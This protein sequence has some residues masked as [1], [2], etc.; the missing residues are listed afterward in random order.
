[1]VTSSK[2][3]IEV[4]DA[5]RLPMTMIKSNNRVPACADWQEVPLL[6]L[7][8]CGFASECQTAQGSSSNIPHPWTHGIERGDSATFL[9]KESRKLIDDDPFH[10][11]WPYW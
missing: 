9:S 10:Y 11:D 1:M 5:E 3:D 2:S 8:N 6:P 4:P 7:A